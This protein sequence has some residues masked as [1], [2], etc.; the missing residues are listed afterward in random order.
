MRMVDRSHAIK[1]NLADSLNVV[2]QIERRPG[3]RFVSEVLEI[4]AY[5]PDA[6]LFDL[7]EVYAVRRQHP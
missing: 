5:N 4:N 1:T 7:S 2:V 3:C 6:D